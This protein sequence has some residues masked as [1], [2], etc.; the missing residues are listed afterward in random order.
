MTS[1][2]LPVRYRNAWAYFSALPCYLIL[3]PIFRSLYSIPLFTLTM[4]HGVKYNCNPDI[5]FSLFW[6]LKSK[7]D[8]MIESIIAWYYLR[9]KSISHFAWRN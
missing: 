5:I 9:R 7:Y 4:Y 3:L 2:Y 6:I 1:D 8:Q